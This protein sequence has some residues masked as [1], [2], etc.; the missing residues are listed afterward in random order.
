MAHEIRH[1]YVSD[2]IHAATGLGSDGAQLFGKTPPAFSTADRSSILAAIRQFESQ[3]GAALVIT[4][5]NNTDD[6]AGDFPF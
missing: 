6:R 3:Q 4:T 2:P 1:L 5:Y